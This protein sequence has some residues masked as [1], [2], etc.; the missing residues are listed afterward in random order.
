[1]EFTLAT[2]LIKHMTRQRKNETN[3]DEYNE[4]LDNAVDALKKLIK[5]W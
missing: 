4:A 5:F 1:M 2:A 3:N